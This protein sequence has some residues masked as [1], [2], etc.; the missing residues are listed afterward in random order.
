LSNSRKIFNDP[1]YGFVEIPYGI[2]FEL[3]EHPYFQRLRRIRQLGLTDMVYPGAIHTRFS[4]AIGALHLMSQAIEVLRSKGTSILPQ[5]AEGVQIAILLHDI[6]H[7]PISHA[8][9]HKIIDVH[10]EKLSQL[11]MEALNEEFEGRLNLAIRIF[12]NEYPKKF[13]YQLVSGQ[14]DM[15]RM[16]YLNR[17]SFFTGV[18][19]GVIGYHR[20]I[21]M[22]T[23]VDN[24]LVVEEKG[25]YS[26]EKFLVAR[27]LMYWQAYLHKTVLGAEQMLIRTVERA[28]KLLSSGEKIGGSERLCRFLKHSFS[29]KDMNEK[30]DLLKDYALLDDTDIWYS[31][32]QWSS[33]TDDVLR[34]LA[35]SLVERRLFKVELSNQEPGEKHIKQLKNSILGDYPQ[36]AETIDD[37][38]IQGSETNSTYST[39]KDEIKIALKG[40]EVVPMSESL[41][42]GIEAKIITKFYLCYPKNKN[43]LYGPIKD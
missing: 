28:R 24:Q 35:K 29:E 41:D 7:G 34:F 18:S 14:L 23:V 26:I 4:H 19:E 16:D 11:F 30:K 10:H 9:E 42:S 17:D 6:G 33:C 2:L 15:D 8:L 37:L 22:L 25:I 27:R 13:L 32:K 3:I 31:L 43:Y 21:K 12:N 5:E 20:I 36:L 1:V 39:S 38:I 40:G